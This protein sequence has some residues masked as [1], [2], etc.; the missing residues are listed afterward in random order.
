MD[1]VFYIFL[2]LWSFYKIRYNIFLQVFFI[3]FFSHQ[4]WFIMTGS[5]FFYIALLFSSCHV[6]S[7]LC[8]TSSKQ[9]SKPCYK[10]MIEHNRSTRER[11][12]EELVIVT[13]FHKHFP[14]LSWLERYILTKGCGYAPCASTT[15]LLAMN[16]NISRFFETICVS[17]L[18]VQYRS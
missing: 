12:N 14:F 8:H 16:Y 3:F 9:F 10:N 11:H 17:L 7:S 2:V 15:F 1:W 5:S 13:F 18:A 4:Q 6:L